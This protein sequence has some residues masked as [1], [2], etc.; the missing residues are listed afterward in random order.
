MIRGRA[1]L[2]KPRTVP[3][4]P[5][6]LCPFVV[7]VTCALT[8]LRTVVDFEYNDAKWKA[9]CY[10]YRPRGYSVFTLRAFSTSASSESGAEAFTLELQRRKVR[11]S[12]LQRQSLARPLAHH[13]MPCA[14]R[15]MP[16]R[17]L[18]SQG[19]HAVFRNTYDAV[20]NA[21]AERR[22]VTPGS[23]AALRAAALAAS[24]RL[25]LAPAPHSAGG[26]GALPPP[27]RIGGPGG[28]GDAPSGAGNEGAPSSSGGAGL[29]DV[30]DA[31]TSLATV[32]ASP[33]DDVAAPA[34]QSIAAL[35]VS[36]RVRAALGHS[37]LATLATADAAARQSRGPPQPIAI[38]TLPA[39]RELRQSSNSSLASASS[40]GAVTPRGGSFSTSPGSAPPQQP[41]MAVSAAASVSPRRGS[42]A[43]VAPQ[44]AL[45]HFA[46]EKEAAVLTIF[47]VLLARIGGVEPSSVECRT[48]AAIAVAELALDDACRHVFLRLGA[49]HALLAATFA[50][51]ASAPTAAL[52]RECLRATYAL[53]FHNEEFAPPPELLRVVATAYPP[54][55][56]RQLETH[57]DVE[58][59][60]LI[61]ALAD[62]LAVHA[63]A[64]PA[65]HVNS[66]HLGGSSGALHSPVPHHSSPL[67]GTPHMTTPHAVPVA[68]SPHTGATPVP[69]RN[70]VG[71]AAPPPA[72]GEAPHVFF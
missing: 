41:P 11:G 72:L 5:F 65:L 59:D 31:F 4:P 57:F 51:V 69:H 32:L 20:I 64:P 33:Y 58:F 43:P 27:P 29:G 2:V 56:L 45:P 47:H 28:A 49:W 38:P 12:R 44:A 67:A 15:W 36:Q 7:A 23:A 9:K 10:V 70:E 8:E 39:V 61:G 62:R 25:S 19:D 35:C 60:A 63:P 54:P 6:F 17:P 24:P 66:P 55:A 3:A 16:T 21:L 48:A 1:A 42:T 14:R 22:V 30:T 53:L 26:D 34:A 52:R 37:A 18:S 40:S 50:V 13:R 71:A 68:S 46:D